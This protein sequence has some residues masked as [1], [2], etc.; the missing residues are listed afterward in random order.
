[1]GNIK[2]I[3]L[4]TS[5]GDAPGMNAGIRA[6]VR[7]AIYH[8]KEVYGIMRGFDGMI[9]NEMIPLTSHF[10]S[11]IIHRG[12]T[13]LK[14]ARSEAFRTAEGMK[15]AAAHLRKMGIDGLVTIGGDGT[16]RGAVAL[17]TLC[18]IPVVGVPGTI[19]NDL[20][21]TEYTLGFDTAVNTALQAIDKIKDTAA[22][23]DRLFFVEVMGR[24]SGFIALWS[25]VAGGVEEVL[26]PETETDIDRLIELLAQRKKHRKSAIVVVAEGDEAGGALK[27]AEKI[28]S[29]GHAFDTRV[30]I[31]GH[32]QRGGDPTAFDRILGTR[33]GAMA[34]EAL[35]GGESGKMTAIAENRYQ[36][37]PL[38]DAVATSRS[39][40]TDLVRY[41]RMMST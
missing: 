26:L 3:G 37:V 14:T 25:G 2:R 18:G 41:L 15:Q 28:N 5:G 6:V 30:T 32:L 12:G 31:L 19:D 27:I 39:P 9:A 11:N 4:L 24:D 17:N 23:H 35:L 7:T 16:F 8:E 22:S 38:A 10:V 33:F 36:L 13:V 21:G 29:K 34:V 40:D 1:M 20:S